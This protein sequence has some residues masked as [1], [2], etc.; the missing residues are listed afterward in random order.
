MTSNAGFSARDPSGATRR[1]PT[2]STSSPSRSS[3]SIV[4]ARRRGRVERRLRRGD[5]E[6]DAGTRRGER[7]RVGADLVGDVAVGGDAV[8]ADDRRRRPARGRSPTARRRR[9]RCGGRCRAARARTPSAGNPAAAAASRRRSPTPGARARAAPARCR[10]PSPTRRT[11]ARRCCSVCARATTRRSSSSSRS[12]PRSASA[13]LVRTSSSHSSTASATTASTPSSRRPTTRRTAHDRFTA[14]GRAAAM[15]SASART[16]VVAEPLALGL[17][18]GEGDGEPAGDA[19]RRRA[20]HGEAAD[21][22]DHRVDVAHLEPLDL[23]RQPGLVD[24][25]GVVAAPLDGAHHADRRIPRRD[26]EPTRSPP[27]PRPPRRSPGRRA[28]P[29]TTSPSC[30]ARAG[31]APPTPSATGTTVAFA[32]LPGFPPPSAGGHVAAV[33]SID[34]RRPPRA[35]VP[36]PPPP[37]RGPRRRR[38]RPPRARRRRRRLPHRRP[39]QRRRVR[40][41]AEWSVGQPVLISDH[42]NLTG[43]SPLTGANPPRRSV[44]RSST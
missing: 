22:V 11:P 17:L 8:G 16:N 3:I 41:A 20:A 30:S 43:R 1:P 14:V 42:I 39:H 4:V 26:H 23:V 12:A 34:A 29:A 18:R 35:R 10:G 15:R 38:R 33:R 44:A 25:D 36:R 2:P 27:P 19:D 6:R 7:Q 37:L 21:G 28:S 13:R 5:D 9:R 31:R 32:D 24:Q 40:C